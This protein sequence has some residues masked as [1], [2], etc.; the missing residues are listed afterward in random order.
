LGEADA[1]EG[2]RRF[3]VPKIKAATEA[4][5]LPGGGTSK[6]EALKRVLDGEGFGK[7][8]LKT[9]GLTNNGEKSVPLRGGKCLGEGGKEQ[10]D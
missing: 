3:E 5:S 9:L 8:E 10:R 4:I 2:I 6:Q 1:G 7:P